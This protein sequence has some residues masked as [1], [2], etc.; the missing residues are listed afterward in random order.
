MD[1]TL[2]E[3]QEMLKTSARDFLKT[4]CPKNL[5][6]QMAVDNKGYTDDLWKQMGEM[7]WLGLVVPEKYGGAGGSFLDLVVLLEE[8]GRACLPG[9]FFATAVLGGL[10]LINAGSEEQKTQF[11]PKLSEGKLLLTLAFLEAGARYSADGIQ[12]KASS[13]G[14]DFALHGT[15]IFVA[16]AHVA[17]YI[18]CAARTGSAANP[19][20]GITLFLVDAKSP[21]ITVTLLKT[22]SGEKQCEVVF[23]NVTVPASNIIGILN[24][25]W[26]VLAL[27]LEKAT[28]A[29]CAE[30]AG[31]A[32][33]MLEIAVDYAKQRKAFGHPIGSFQIIQHYCSNM[34]LDSDGCALMVHNAAWLLSEGLPATRQVSM[35]KAITNEGLRHVASLSFQ[36]HGAIAFTEDHDIP[37]YYKR[38]KTWEISLG[39]THYHLDKVAALS[40]V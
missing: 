28:V 37:V 13:H 18:I 6:R 33:Y 11:L 10:T 19:E 3:M 40:N 30:M 12:M 32:R 15:K 4:Y 16:D 22:I 26:N 31:A 7:G 5:I 1:L 29:R 9:P 14:G 34:L 24:K 35:T 21:G 17:D 36:T 8:M 25:G 27:A 38:A 23:D 20:D 2:T 39:G